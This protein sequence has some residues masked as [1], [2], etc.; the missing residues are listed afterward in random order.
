MTRLLIV[1]TVPETLATILKGQ[2]RHLSARFDVM[3][4]SSAADTVAQVQQVEGI[5][6]HTVPMV[7]GIQLVADLIAVV[8]MVLLIRTLR[9][10]IVH[11]YTPKAG[12]VCMLAGWLCRV[13]VRVHT[14]TG[15]I[16][17]TA[18]GFRQKLLIWIDRLICA[19]AT[20]VVPEGEGVKR[21][22]QAYRITR[23]P[24]QVI[25][26][27]NIAGVDT[28]WFSPG[29]AQ[30]AA[31]GTDLRTRLGIG[32]DEFV[33]TFVGRLNADKGLNE[34]MQAFATLAPAAHLLMVGGQTHP[35]RLPN[36]WWRPCGRTRVCTCWGLF[37]IFAPHCSRPMCWFCPATARVFP[38][39]CSRRARWG[40][41]LLRR[42][43][44]V[45]TR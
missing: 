37:T 11:S 15:L 24:L 9:P 19:C 35:P 34:L 22:L 32:L 28:G 44:T 18:Q 23:K 40:C 16:F 31:A 43:S 36:R 2:P 8:R 39:C 5:K 42:M 3:L 4:A 26:H 6:V 13:P 14:F 20:H 38:T 27:G 12:L 21:D 1:T 29:A 33:F 7:R 45:A 25:G 10:D 41:P 30:M 17:P